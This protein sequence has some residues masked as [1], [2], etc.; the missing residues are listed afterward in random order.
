[1]IIDCHV[2]TG[3]E[4]ASKEELLEQLDL[5][6]IGRMVLLS[7]HPASFC[8]G[9]NADRPEAPAAALAQ[10]MDWAAFSDRIIP[11]YW[12]DPLEEDA[13]DQVEKAAAAG[14]AGFKVICNR[15][16]PG[17]KRP[18]QVWERIAKTGRPILFHSGILYGIGPSSQYNRPVGFE[19]LFD[20]P[21]LRFALAHVSWPWCD[22]NL[23]V[24]GYWQNRRQHGTTSAEMFIDTTPGTPLIYRREVFSKIYHI[25]YD[26]ENNVIFGTDNSNNYSSESTKR[27]LAMDRD[28]LD[29]AGVSSEQ[30]EKYY[31]KNFLRFL[32][33]TV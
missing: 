17:D 3:S 22:E 32:G 10:V 12:I 31:S 23:A 14:I 20:I 6:G 15:H 26:I 2:H 4:P 25:G 28:A 1:M 30:R 33:S 5:S 11:F 19:P 7:Y 21:G 16:F 13:F 27:I 24:Y 8:S 9:L 18:M 29:F